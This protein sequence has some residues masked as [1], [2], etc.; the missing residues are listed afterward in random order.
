[1]GMKEYY[2]E[3]K[4]KVKAQ[5]KAWREANPELVK[6]LRRESAARCR[7]NNPPKYIRDML[8]KLYR[9]RVE[10]VERMFA[11]QAGR[12]KC[13]GDPI[14]LIG[15]RKNPSY[16]NIDHDH[17]TNRVRG[18]LCGLCNRMLGQAKESIPRL[19]AGINYLKGQVSHFLYR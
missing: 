19:Q 18:L 2:A 13:C 17:E 15:G 1:M 8:W 11:E 16:R 12:C 10:D 3:N 7:L 6:T 14:S 4:E 5:N 9:L